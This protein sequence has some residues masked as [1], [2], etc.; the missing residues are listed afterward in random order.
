SRARWIDPFLFAA[1]AV[2]A[3][4]LC[5]AT[6]M[7]T[8][9]L[10]SVLVGSVTIV[11]CLLELWDAPW[12][13]SPR[14]EIAWPLILRRTGVKW[15]GV[16]AGVAMLLTAWWALPEYRQPRYRA[17][18]AVSHIL[19]PWVPFATVPS[20]LWAEWRIGPKEDDRWHFG[21]LLLGRWKEIDWQQIRQGLMGWFIKGFFLPVNFS[22]ASDLIGHFRGMEGQLLSAEWPKAVFFADAMMFA[23]L[24]IAIL[25]GYLFSARIFNNELKKVDCTWFGWVVTLSCYPPFNSVVSGRWF[26]YESKVDAQWMPPW[27]AWGLHS[28]GVAHL[29][30]GILLLLEFFHFWG[31]SSFGLRSSN[32]SNRGILTNGPYRFCKHPIYLSKC[33]GWLII[34][35]PIGLGRPVSEIFR[36]LL[37]FCSWCG[38]YAM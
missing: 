9:L 16:M 33:V 36:W 38:I 24:G 28:M 13:N 17:F 32:L 5:R 25:P 35:A 4:G 20:I 23:T 19:L 29:I 3:Y 7:S 1:I 2:L 10:T 34:W 18:F 21:L 30:G 31:E 15:L 12:R 8:P 6:P 11:M 14:P 37:L 27:T 22:G 26:A